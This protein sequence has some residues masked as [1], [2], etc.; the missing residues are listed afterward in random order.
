MGAD[1][2]FYHAQS[3]EDSEQGCSERESHRSAYQRAQG[4]K[5]AAV[6]CPQETRGAGS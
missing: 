2:V 4:G 6:G 3:K 5:R 1:F